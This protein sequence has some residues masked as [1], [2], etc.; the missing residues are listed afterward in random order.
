MT[1]LSNHWGWAPPLFLY[2]FLGIKVIVY[3]YQNFELFVAAWLISEHDWV[4]LTC[5]TENKLPKWYFPDVHCFARATPL[6]IQ[7]QYITNWLLYPIWYQP[8]LFKE[9]STANWYYLLKVNRNWYSSVWIRIKSSKSPRRRVWTAKCTSL[10][11]LF[12]I[13]FSAC[14]GGIVS[15]FIWYLIYNFCGTWNSILFVWFTMLDDF[16]FFKSFHSEPKIHQLLNV[17]VREYQASP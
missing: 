17:I 8:A 15:R 12:H 2:L 11:L 4:Q 9:R 7:V 3:V 13:K 14:S 6:A 5:C 10:L 16:P 1:P